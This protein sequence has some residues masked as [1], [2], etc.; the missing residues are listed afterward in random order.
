MPPANKIRL[1]PQERSDRLQRA[2]FSLI[3]NDAFNT[4]MDELREQQHAAVMDSINDKVVANERLTLTA[5][6][7][8][9]AYQG[10]IGM[11]DDFVQTRLMEADIEAERRIS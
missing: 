6:G 8:I 1:T 7:E 11:Y 3:G 10:I 4:F 9:R 2:M 5:L